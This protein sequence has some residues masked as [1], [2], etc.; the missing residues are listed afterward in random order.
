MPLLDAV[1]NFEGDTPQVLY[2]DAFEFTAGLNIAA[3]LSARSWGQGD[4]RLRMAVQVLALSGRLWRSPS[5]GKRLSDAIES[6]RRQ[7]QAFGVGH[8]NTLQ[9]MAQVY[10]DTIAPLGSRIMVSGDPAVLTQDRIVTQIRALL[11]A[12]MRAA[13]LWRHLDGSVWS[14]YFMRGR[15]HREFSALLPATPGGGGGEWGPM[16]LRR[17]HQTAISKTSRNTP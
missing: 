3:A 11:L 6:A 12:A 13:I 10:V 17:R 1:F 8:E 2:G 14:L 9:A 15:W 16:T 7:Q 5:A 4:E